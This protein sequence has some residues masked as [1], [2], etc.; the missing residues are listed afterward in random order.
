MQSF[1]IDILNTKAMRLLEDLESLELIRLRK[2][3]DQNNAVNWSNY[4]GAMTRQPLAEID[5]Q[6]NDLREGWE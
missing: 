5:K 2:T 3:T 4:K 1:V 6:L